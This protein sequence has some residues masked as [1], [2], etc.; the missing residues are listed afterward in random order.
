M[1]SSQRLKHTTGVKRKAT[2]QNADELA[3]CLEAAKG[4]QDKWKRNMP[5]LAHQI[6]P[7]VPTL[8][9]D[10]MGEVHVNFDACKSAASVQR[11]LAK[12]AELE[13]CA[14]SEEREAAPRPKATT[15]QKSK[16]VLDLEWK[17]KVSAEV[18]KVQRALAQKAEKL[19]GVAMDV[20]SNLEPCVAEE[21]KTELN[22]LIAAAKE[23]L[24]KWREEAEAAFE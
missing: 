8:H 4:Q 20:K 15:P 6:V 16:A 10:L 1:L 5:H 3:E 11:D 21:E 2:A 13:A 23:A 9:A 14:A 12:R 17:T 24:A 22:R 7:T 19:E 18:S